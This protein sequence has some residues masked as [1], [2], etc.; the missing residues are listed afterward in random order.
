MRWCRFFEYG[1]AALVFSAVVALSLA[2]ACSSRDAAQVRDTTAAANVAAVSRAANDSAPVVTVYKSPTCGC[3]TAWVDHLRQSGF[4]VVA[5]DTTDVE[6][7]KRRYGVASEH[8][9]CH[10]AVVGG[11]VV[12]GHVPAEDIRRLLAQR[13]PITGLAVPG[14]PVGSPGMEGAYKQAYEVLAFRRGGE[15]TVFAKH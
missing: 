13:P 11:Y 1:R 12:E 9:A 7:V 10:T 8:A 3:C 4:R 5:I 6:A 14:M 2:G 15:S